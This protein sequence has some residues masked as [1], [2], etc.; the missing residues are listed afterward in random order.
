MT[1]EDNPHDFQ[2]V[3]DE[4]L[5]AM[6][7]TVR[8]TPA[9][10]RDAYGKRIA[11]GEAVTSPARLETTHES[12]TTEDGDITVANGRAFLGYVIPW[13]TADDTFEVQDLEGKWTEVTMVSVE[14][15]Y[16]PEGV[17]H[18]EVWYGGRGAVRG[19]Q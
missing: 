5:D 18:Q 1:P 11:G 9:Q 3:E 12:F 14:A 7:S 10:R 19:R 6:P 8:C 4:Y 13:L 16:G 15:V 17:H 2:T